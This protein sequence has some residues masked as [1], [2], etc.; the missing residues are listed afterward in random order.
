MDYYYVPSDNGHRKVSQKGFSFHRFVVFLLL[1]AVVASAI[2]WFLI[3][4]RSPEG[5]FSEG[6]EIGKL[7]QMRSE[8]ES[9][10]ELKRELSYDPV[11]LRKY[12]VKRGDSLW[13][14]SRKTGIS[15]E[16][17]VVVNSLKS[18]KVWAGQVL[19]IP[20][21]EGFFYTV[22]KGDTIWEIAR[23]FR[24]EPDRL[25]KINGSSFIKP[26][27]K[28]FIP[29]SSQVKVIYRRRFAPR[30]PRRFF[31]LRPLRGRI[32]SRFGWR[33]DPFTGK[34]AFHYGVDISAPVGTPVRAAASG[35]VIYAGWYGGY[36][37]VV[38]IKHSLGYTTV[39]GHL[40][41]IVVNPGQVVKKGQIIGAVGN[42]GRSTGPHLHFEIR[43]NGRAINP[44]RFVKL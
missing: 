36:G 40:S 7:L 3:F 22:R 24:V 20:D 28:L 8:K 32:T 37:N 30:K 12:I 4:R 2:L 21:R 13:S 17:I 33:K 27:E 16:T 35:M 43:K 15:I 11:S 38:I 19:R 31:F 26:G 25:E 5:G 29:G 14:I 9:L 1:T 6:D 18:H 41:A 42:T 23:K 34:R 39:Y 44:L 10:S